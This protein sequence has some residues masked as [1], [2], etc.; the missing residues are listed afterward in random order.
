MN[1]AWKSVRWWPRLTTRFT[2][3]NHIRN[4]TS[5]RIANHPA[6]GLAAQK[7]DNNEVRQKRANGSF[8]GG[9]LTEGRSRSR[10]DAYRAAA[11]NRR[12]CEAA[13]EIRRVKTDKL[14]R[15]EAHR[16]REAAGSS[17][18]AESMKSRKLV[19]KALKLY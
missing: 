10:W 16:A 1:S 8:T 2:A 15:M 18:L 13:R 7:S 5:L 6:V 19:T 12:A 9:K 11:T 3:S 17:L 14:K 4:S